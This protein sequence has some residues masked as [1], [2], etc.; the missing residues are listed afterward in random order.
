M[1][2]VKRYR[3]SGAVQAGTSADVADHPP[4]AEKTTGDGFGIFATSKTRRK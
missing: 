4:A 1:D 2:N 3:A